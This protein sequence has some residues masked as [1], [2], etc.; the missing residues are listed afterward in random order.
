MRT[1]QTNDWQ[2]RWAWWVTKFAVPNYVVPYF[3]KY[4]RKIKKKD[5]SNRFYVCLCNAAWKTVQKFRSTP[6]PPPPIPSFESLHGP[7]L[8]LRIWNGMHS[9]CKLLLL[10]IHSAYP[11]SWPI[12]III[13]THIVSQSV[14]S[15]FRPDFQNKTN[16]NG[17]QCSLLTRQWVW[18]SG[19]CLNSCLII[20]FFWP[21]AQKKSTLRGENCSLARNF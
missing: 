2:C 5:T 13:F 11:Q 4:C 1:K 6:S 8:H 18:P 15:F 17:K 3:S 7:G 20:L 12:V 21:K 9:F 10:M 14:R 16:F 19:S